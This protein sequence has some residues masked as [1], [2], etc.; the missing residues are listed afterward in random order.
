M[1]KSPAH[2]SEVQR[3]AFEKLSELVVV[4]LIDQI[5]VHSPNVLNT[6]LE[7]FMRYETTMIGQANDHVAVGYANALHFGVRRRS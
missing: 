7:A 6:R 3:L 2:L 1:I 4:H 5:L